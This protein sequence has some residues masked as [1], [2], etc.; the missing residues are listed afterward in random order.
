MIIP[1][2]YFSSSNNTAFVAMMIARGLE[3]HDFQPE[4]LKVE[5][6]GDGKRDIATAQIIGLGAPVYGGSFAEPIRNWAK[7]FDFTG[8]RIFLFS[9]AANAHFGSA[10]EMAGIVEKNGGLVIGALEM[11]FPGSM[12]GVFYS[13][14]LAEKH[15]LH[16][17]DL[18]AAVSFGRAV[19][20][21]ARKGEGYADYT[22][23]HHFG[24]LLLPAVKAIKKVALA[25]VKRLIFEENC[26]MCTNCEACSKVCPVDALDAEGKCAKIDRSKCIACFRCFK[27]CPEGSLALRFAENREYYRGPWQLKGYVDPA[28]LGKRPE[29]AAAEK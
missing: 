7:A 28:D 29:P 17:P 22:Y 12:W 5:D 15:P 9:T 6:A 14:K 3:C 25:I 4:L 8:K 19:A 20:E 2:V 27:Q 18:E 26:G 1:V 10:H 21:I 24:T 23:T 16:R 11:K 13:K